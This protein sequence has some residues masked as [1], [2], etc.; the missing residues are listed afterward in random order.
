[1]AIRLVI[2]DDH[3]F[4]IEALEAL[5]AATDDMEVVTSC[6]DGDSTLAAV[7]R[8]SPDILL[9]DLSMPGLDGISVLDEL[10]S[11]S[12]DTNV[13]VFTGAMD[14]KRALDCLRLGA[15]GVVLKG[16]PSK[17]LMEAIRRVAAGEVW[18]DKEVYAEAMTRMLRQENTHRQLSTLLTPREMDTLVLAAKGESNKEIAREL[19]VTEGTVKLH[20]HHVFDKLGLQSRTELIIYA[21][22]HGLA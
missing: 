6:G 9:L 18:L 7:R 11:E 8:H 2:A 13:V 21:Y 14:E 12:C 19:T 17:Q 5:F 20:L 16:A 4:V 22:E 3:P 1:M 15:S 10:K